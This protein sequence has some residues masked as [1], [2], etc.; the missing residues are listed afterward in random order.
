[1]KEKQDGIAL[2][3]A[4][5]TL[6]FL[7]LLVVVTLDMS[8]TDQQIVTNQIKDMQATYIADAGI[9]NSVYQLR[10]NSSYTGTGGAVEFPI[11][12]GNTYNVTVS[13]GDTIISTG[14]VGTFTR[15]LEAKY[16]LSGSSAPYTVRIIRWKEQ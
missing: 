9:E 10:Q 14:T 7:S 6:L 15:K 13:G 11:G 8:T 5:F 4:L 16:S 1:M 3:L 12:S 2:I